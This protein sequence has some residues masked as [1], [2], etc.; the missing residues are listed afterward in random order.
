VSNA[1]DPNVAIKLK[2]GLVVVA[3]L[4]GIVAASCL[5]Y[6]GSRLTD[7]GCLGREPERSRLAECVSQKKPAGECLAEARVACVLEK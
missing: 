5:I 2:M 4:L 3:V 1:D 6:L 7:L